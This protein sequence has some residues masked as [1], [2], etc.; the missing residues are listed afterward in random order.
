MN[1]RSRSISAAVAAVG[2]AASLMLTATP[3][4]AAAC[5]IGYDCQTTWYSDAAKTNAVGGEWTSCDGH[6]STWGARGPYQ[7]YSRIRC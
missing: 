3:A 4:Q 2:I 5:P 6:T 1:V 7:N